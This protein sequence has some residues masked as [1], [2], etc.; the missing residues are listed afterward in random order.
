MR[1]I[2][3]FQPNL[4]KVYSRTTSRLNMRDREL[5]ADLPVA[6]CHKIRVKDSTRIDFSQV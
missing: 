2:T 6:P 3:V 1:E 4:K 5:Q